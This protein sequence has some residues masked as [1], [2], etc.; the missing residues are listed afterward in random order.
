[1]TSRLSKSTQHQYPLTQFTLPVLGKGVY[2]RPYTGREQKIFAMAQESKDIKQII[3]SIAQIL[4]NVVDQQSEAAYLFDS[5]DTILKSVPLV[6]INF[7][8]VKLRAISDNTIAK[9][10]IEDP[11]TGE[12]VELA[13]DLNKVQVST[14]KGHTNKLDFGRFVLQ[15][16]Y[17]T[18]SDYLMMLDGDLPKARKD[19]LSVRNCLYSITFVEE[20]DVEFFGKYMDEEVEE[21]LDSLLTTQIASITEFFAT[22]PV[23][24]HEIPYKNSLGN[25][26]TFVIEGI[27]SFFL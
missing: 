21:W 3:V 12:E 11:E 4:T 22:A 27:E 25:D 26:K 19:F 15:M 1:M 2:V 10:V 24:R 7:L 13:L 8:M 20:G 18:L 9:F 16:S 14:P 5:I 23:L 6:D 17:P